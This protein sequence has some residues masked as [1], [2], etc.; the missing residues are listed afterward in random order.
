MPGYVVKAATRQVEVATP[1]TPLRLAAASTPAEQRYAS[2]VY[3]KAHAANAASVFISSASASMST[4]GYIIAAG[5]ELKLEAAGREWDLYD[6][7]VDA[8]SANSKVSVLWARD[9]SF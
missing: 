7:F 6:L 9:A 8:V 3:I 4:T 2:V 1:G 5:G